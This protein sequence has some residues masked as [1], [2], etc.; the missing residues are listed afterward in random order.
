MY[1]TTTNVAIITDGNLGGGFFNQLT[2][3]R[4]TTMI[5]TIIM[6]CLLGLTVIV[7]GAIELIK[8][9]RIKNNLK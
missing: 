4:R 6:I 7:P 2:Q 9:I 8:E 5:V 3:I 1:Y